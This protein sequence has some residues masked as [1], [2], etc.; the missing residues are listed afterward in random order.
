MFDCFSDS[1]SHF[2]AYSFVLCVLI[3]GSVAVMGFLTFGDGTLSQITLNMPPG[4]ISSK[5]A[6][7]TTVSFEIFW[8]S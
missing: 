3:Y 4:A 6:L 8:V 5:V 2:F 1:W 7:W